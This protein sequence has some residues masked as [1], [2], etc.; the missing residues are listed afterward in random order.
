MKLSIKKEKNW[1]LFLFFFI[2]ILTIVIVLNLFENKV[3]NFFYSISFPFQN[4]FWQSGKKIS[5]FFEGISQFKNLKKEN[6]SLK[7]KIQEL[8]AQN[9]SLLE[10]KKENESLRNALNIGLEKEF[11]LILVKVIGKDI[12]QD[13]LLI[14]KGAKDGIFTELPVITQEK[15]LV[16]KITKVYENFSKVML[17]TDKNSSFSAKV[18]DSDPEIFGIAKGK[19]N[20]KVSFEMV[21]Q[22]KEIKEG[23]ILVTSVLGGVFPPGILVGKL[24]NIKKSDLKPFQ[25]ADIIPFF[26]EKELDFLFIIIS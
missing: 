12:S 11:K 13:F 10:L 26:N 9:A 8:L 7:S 5:N 20:L 22:E 17:I 21:P 2:L 18:S 24:E 23:D 14:N 4:F 25:E 16:G 19:G 1:L 6:E 15:V 3:K